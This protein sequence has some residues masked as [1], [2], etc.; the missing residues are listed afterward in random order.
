MSELFD[1]L[2]PFR[3]LSKRIVSSLA[4]VVLIVMTIGSAGILMF[5]ARQ[6]R[7][8]LTLEARVLSRSISYAA[9]TFTNERDLRRL[10]NTLGA[11]PNVDMISVIGRLEDGSPYVI[12]SSRNAWIDLPVREIRE[13]AGR[14]ETD[15]NLLGQQQRIK[16]DLLQSQTEFQTHVM[17]PRKSTDPVAGIVIVR[18]DTSGVLRSAAAWAATLSF[19]LLATLGLLAWIGFCLLKRYVLVP[20]SQISTALRDG[21]EFARVPVMRHDEIGIL[22]STLND[23]HR[24][25]A[26]TTV[27][28]A[29]AQED[30]ER[31]FR[32]V[33][34]L[35]RA[36]DEH[37]I[38][39]ITDASGK[40]IDVN[41][42]F[43]KISGYTR[44][45]LLGKNHR[46]LN[47]GLHG[48]LFW[49]DVWRMITRGHA[50]RG[51]VCNKR[52]DGTC[53]WVDSTIVPYL[54]A[55]GAPEKFVSIRF[56]I[57]AQKAAEKA[58]VEARAE[59]R[60]ESKSKS[61]FLANMSHEIRT[62]MTAILGFTDLL[63]DAIGTQT[64]S[65]QQL[66]F[67][68]TIRRNG[69][70]LLALINDVLDL[71]K[72]EADRIAIEE[73]PVA[74]D[75]IVRDVIELM[76]VKSEA[77]DLQLSSSFLT[78]VPKKLQI[79]PLRVRQVLV[80]LVGNA[81]K[82]TEQ[83]KVEIKCGYERD[84][85]WFEVVDSGIGICEE[86]QHRLFDPFEQGD[87]STNRQYGG[88][89]LGLH[90]S[91]RLARIMG[92]AITVNSKLGLGSTFRFTMSA[93]PCDSNDDASDSV[94][95]PQHWIEAGNSFLRKG[96]PDE[97]AGTNDGLPLQG[98]R[99]L[100]AE[101]GPDNIV[102]LTA[103][104]ER[105]GASVTTV[106]NGRRAVETLTANGSLDG[107]LL[108]D[109]GFDIFLTDVQMPE[110]DG[111]E[112][113][114]RLRAKGCRLP[115]IALT[116]HAMEGDE[117]KCLDAG[118]DGYASKPVNRALLIGLCQRA[119][120]GRLPGF[121]AVPLAA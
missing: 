17:L 108:E 103:F 27:E 116:A 58:L 101:D 39:S 54:N 81:I 18:L 118:C 110:M 33:A 74:V 89:G 99:V 80:N 71:S 31:A 45:E 62:P 40:I 90:I 78:R 115:I 56:D 13:L 22:A 95:P 16:R 38:L 100:L 24:D 4:V 91:Q 109:L 47:S 68:D 106:P 65:S 92:G 50:W 76:L 120:D 87:N 53:Y 97:I 121:D 43:C 36:L 63:R 14:L 52:K 64:T 49:I 10:V 46:I 2:G 69:E 73:E 25:A 114:R 94:N 79:D 30:A 93:M 117:Q 83:G 15:P 48:K 32:E 75:E 84:S 86:N 26:V 51:E 34:A 111:Y 28:L 5:S 102:L 60:A 42:G 21:G 1:Q 9:E 23:A 67:V 3:S 7:Q 11:E 96:Q 8:S 119:L 72:I 85:L 12:A 104:L 61:E 112:A 82:F 6:S 77:K 55:K 35:R 98:A 107:N 113:A 37:L 20:I 105:A 44:E 70:H 19:G 29:S 66:E 88:T 59:A 57:T 41:M